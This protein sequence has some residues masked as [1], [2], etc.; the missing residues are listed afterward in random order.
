[1]PRGAAEE[2]RA[3]LKI[4]VAR[5]TKLLLVYILDWANIKLDWLVLR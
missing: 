4:P 2:R 5:A 1:M 3:P